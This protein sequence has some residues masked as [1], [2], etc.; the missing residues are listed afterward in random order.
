MAKRLEIVVLGRCCQ[1]VLLFS[2]CVGTCD[3]VALCWGF[4]F[5]VGVVV[6]EIV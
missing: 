1:R 5:G 2:F 6:E 4:W 3:C